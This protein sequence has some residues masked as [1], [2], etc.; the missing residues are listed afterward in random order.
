MRDSLRIVKD[1]SGTSMI[2]ALLF[3]LVATMVSVVLLGA[4]TTA[5][6][7]VHAEQERTQAMLTLRSAGDIVRQNLRSAACSIETKTNIET[8]AKTTTVQTSDDG[9][10]LNTELQS[11]LTQAVAGSTGGGTFDIIVPETADAG[12]L[13]GSQV[14]VRYT[15]QPQGDEEDGENLYK[16]DA[17]L[18]LD[19][20]DG[21]LF[22][23][24]TRSSST[25]PGTTV[26]D[27]VATTTEP[28]SW[29]D[30]VLSTKEGSAS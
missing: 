8:G 12:E 18:S 22:L 16:I 17:T 23:T 27:G 25:A 4:S 15:M 29:S 5:L 2:Y 10:P 24:A 19:G 7:R 26:S 30:V 20:Y 21:R 11:A 13:A 28:V 1:E 9:N 6:E 3:L 14:T